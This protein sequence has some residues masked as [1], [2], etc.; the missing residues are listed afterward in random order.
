MSSPTPEERA[1]IAEMAGEIAK[2]MIVAAA[3]D[4]IKL[5]ATARS[6]ARISAIGSLLSVEPIH[7]TF[8][9]L[10]MPQ[11]RDYRKEC[12]IAAYTRHA[13]ADVLTEKELRDLADA[14][15]RAFD[16]TFPA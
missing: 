10:E 11:Q 4:L 13:A 6:D 9:A 16:R 1:I 2:A 7:G 15:V 12:W 8:E 14:A 3:P 5:I